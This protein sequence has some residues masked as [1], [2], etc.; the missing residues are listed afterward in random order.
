MIEELRKLEEE[1]L[2]T[3]RP[4]DELPLYI[5]NYSREVQYERLWN[6][7][8]LITQCRGLIIDEDGE[9][10][11]RPMKKFFNYE[12]HM[13]VDSLPDIPN[14]PFDVYEKMDGSCG[15][16]FFYD[17]S[18]IISTRGSFHSDQA[19]YANEVLLPKYDTSRLDKSK[20]YLFEIIID[21]NRIVVN[22]GDREELVLL[23]CIDS[24]TG[25]E[26]DI[27]GIDWPHKAEKYDFKSFNEILEKMEEFDDGN[28]EGFVVK[29][30]SIGRV[31]IK[32]E[33]YVRLHRLLTGLTKRTIWELLKDGEDIEKIYDTAPD[34]VYD[35][36]EETVN[37]LS[38]RHEN[39]SI[40]SDIL[41][42]SIIN[43]IGAKT[44]FDTEEEESQYRKEFAQSALSNEQVQEYGLQS[45]MFRMFDGRSID[46]LI[47][48]QIKPEHE[49]LE[50]IT[51]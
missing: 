1:G 21:W 17:G 51:N 37:E 4:H 12:E 25:K 45:V 30:E 6:E 13:D 48:R 8:P 3:L 26:T 47:W 40:L 20:T 5:A 15:I 29:F 36:V 35:W 18:W 38:E 27:S 22:Y 9:V 43:S 7:H 42:T 14:E 2:I 11:A 50:A 19:E 28:S 41:Y 34:E 39:L 32:L 46:D 33:E 16:C 24:K 10:I 23:A 31:K 49:P 44:D